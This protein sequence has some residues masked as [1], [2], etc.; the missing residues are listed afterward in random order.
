MQFIDKQK[1]IIPGCL[2]VSSATPP[3]PPPPCW[4]CSSQW[5]NNRRAHHTHCCSSSPQGCLWKAP[6]ASPPNGKLLAWYSPSSSRSHKTPV[7][8]Q[9]N[10]V[11]LFLHPVW[12]CIPRVPP[13]QGRSRYPTMP[14]GLWFQSFLYWGYESWEPPAV[15]T[16]VCLMFSCPSSDCSHLDWNK[17]PRLMDIPP[18]LV[19]TQQGAQHSIPAQPRLG[20][21][22][23]PEERDPEHHLDATHLLLRKRAHHKLPEEPKRCR[24][25]WKGQ[26]EDRVELALPLKLFNVTLFTVMWKA[27]SR[28][29]WLG[30]CGDTQLLMSSLALS[31]HGIPT[32]ASVWEMKH[33]LICFPA[34]HGAWQLGHVLKLCVQVSGLILQRHSCVP[35]A[36]GA[37]HPGRSFAWCPGARYPDNGSA[38]PAERTSN[39]LNM[40]L[41]S[42]CLRKLCLWGRKK[43]IQESKDSINAP[44]GLNNF[45]IA[46]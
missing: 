42:T 36:S 45:W 20:D 10:H 26:G 30:E 23:R 24:L 1:I 17:K 4:Q 7:M 14:S 27:G 37:R 19:T 40:Y 22:G 41:S 9:P 35:S 12:H 44:R 3:P 31:S 28:P 2:C 43:V 11:L 21:G 32:A 15:T 6:E 33:V 25:S 38:A 13:N 29:H 5:F 16:Q 34:L 18:L 8:W 39:L 46:Q